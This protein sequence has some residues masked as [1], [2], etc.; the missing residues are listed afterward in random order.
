MFKYKNKPTYYKGKRFDSLKEANRFWELSIL[1]QA[2]NISDLK[3]QVAYQL[4][5]NDVI[6]GKYICDFEYVQKQK[7]ITEDVKSAVTKKLP[8]YRWKK[9]HF[10]AQYGR[11]IKEV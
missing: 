11:E 3:C 5:V 8:L 9:K 4:K 7:T 2:G 1:E 6:I 10:Q